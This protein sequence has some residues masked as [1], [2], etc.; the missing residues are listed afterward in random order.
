MLYKIIAIIFPLIIFLLLWKANFG[1]IDG[2]PL[3][4]TAKIR[5]QEIFQAVRVYKSIHETYPKD[6]E[7]LVKGDLKY[8]CYLY[9][10]PKDPWGK[11]YIFILKEE[12]YEIMSLGADGKT[13]GNGE[14]EDIIWNSK[15][16]FLDEYVKKE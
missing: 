14:N 8:G 15:K 1:K 9:E 10:I 16:G 6:L 4:N 12:V 13:G 5:I 7:T 11:Y 2:I 3:K